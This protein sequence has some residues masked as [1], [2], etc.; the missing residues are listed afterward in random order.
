MSAATEES[1]FEQVREIL[2]ANF[3]I[4]PEKV[5]PQATFRGSFGMDSLDIVD[6]V[7]FLQK[8]FGIQGELDDYRE[9]HTMQNLCRFV[10]DRMSSPSP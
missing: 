6:L 5:T 1:V 9:L 2:R 3:N 7:F 10:L 8:H 4:P